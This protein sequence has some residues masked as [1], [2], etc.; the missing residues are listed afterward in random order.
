MMPGKKKKEKGKCKYTMGNYKCSREALP[1]DEHCIFHS[2]NIEGKKKEFDKKFRKEFESQKER[3]DKHDFTGFVFPEDISFEGIEF[4]KNV[5]F[6]HAQFSGVTDFKGVKFSRIAFFRDAKFSG[7][8]HFKKAKFFGMASFEKAKFLGEAD[9]RDAQFSK[10]IDFMNA[11]FKVAHFDKVQ[12]PG[13][14]CFGGAKFFKDAFFWGVEF[15]GFAR[16]DNAQFYQMAAFGKVQFK[17]VLFNDAQFSGEAV[18]ELVQFHMSANFIKTT[19]SREAHFSKAQFPGLAYFRGAKF[20]GKTSFKEVQFSGKADFR[21]AKFFGKTSFKEVQ[22]SG[23]ADFRGA[24]FS[25][26]VNFF[27][28]TFSGEELIGLFDSLRIRGIKRIVKGSYKK[29]DFKFHLGEKIAKEYPVIDRMTKDAWYLDDFK[30]NHPIIYGIWW[31]FAD[32]GR[33]FFRWAAWSFG[34]AI[35]FALI[36]YFGFY[37][38]YPLNFLTVYVIE[39]YPFL[40]FLYYSIVTFTTLGFG[41]IVPNTGWL[42]FWVAIEVILGYIMLGFLISIG[43]QKIARRS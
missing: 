42:Q 25:G 11:Q 39:Q 8:T 1:G 40:T 3:K 15:S 32:C 35:A 33:S 37:R 13:E 34:F 29:L 21:D 36:Y 7:K 10:W 4:K 2:E 20:F 41:D 28:S 16:F 19:F 22:F 17:E 14:A 12:F 30:A 43:A 9:F 23:K 27:R 26:E 38:D 5:M 6:D 24:K 31:L 18:F